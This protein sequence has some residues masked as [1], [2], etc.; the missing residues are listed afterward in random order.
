M[1]NIIADQSQQHLQPLLSSQRSNQNRH[2][3]VIAVVGSGLSAI[4]V[5]VVPYLVARSIYY[6]ETGE[7]DF[8]FEDM[9]HSRS[10]VFWMS[11]PL[12]SILAVMAV[13]PFNVYNMYKLIHGTLHSRPTINITNISKFMLSTLF[14][15]SGT[16]NGY[17][18]NY[19]I[20]DVLGPRQNFVRSL[21]QFGCV[22][23]ATAVAGIGDARVVSAGLS[24]QVPTDY[25]YIR[26]GVAK[27]SQRLGIFN[28][29]NTR[30]DNSLN[31]KQLLKSIREQLDDLNQ[32]ISLGLS[33]DELDQNSLLV[34]DQT[35]IDNINSRQFDQFLELLNKD[36]PVTRFIVSNVVE[37]ILSL[38]LAYFGNMNTIHYAYLA[39]SEFFE[40]IGF[41]ENTIRFEL[42]AGGFAT[43]GYSVGFSLSFFLI[44]SLFFQDIAKNNALIQPIGSYAKTFLPLI[45][46][47]SFGLLNVILTATN[48]D[49]SPYT[50]LFVSCSAIIGAT[51]VLRYGI[52]GGVTE[53]MGKQNIRTEFTGIV[54]KFMEHCLKLDNQALTEI[55]EKLAILKSFDDNQQAMSLS[56]NLNRLP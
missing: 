41:P 25:R 46:A 1:P 28:N 32:I 33:A 17:N 39:F 16:V 37:T 51:V 5:M 34:T 26:R 36:F 38:F 21:F 56:A 10:P 47:F 27:I 35:W 7:Q 40:A 44:R 9:V 54:E 3:K 53:F 12:A 42:L 6:L 19:A 45:P 48:D 13:L 49:L 55:H 18:T 31:R 2:V 50:K 11:A 23:V 24:Q 22:G 30:L 14:V 4:A 52:Q 29:Q 20:N 15:S 8:T 43:L